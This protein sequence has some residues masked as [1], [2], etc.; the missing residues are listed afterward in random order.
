MRR[1]MTVRG[2]LL[3]GLSATALAAAFAPSAAAR[4]FRRSPQILRVE[5]PL[6]HQ[7][8]NIVIPFVVADVTGRRVDVE[9]QYA[10]DYNADGQITD[11][12]Y[13]PATED[14]L[15]PRNSRADTVPQLYSTGTE[16]GATHAY[17]WKSFSD[18]GP[19]R[20]LT[21]EYVLSP[22]G[23][24]V[25][26]P[27]NP[28]RYLLVTG[29][30]GVTTFLPGVRVRLRTVVARRGHRRRT[31]GDWVVT[32]S[33]SVDNSIP[34]VL[35]ID[36]IESGSPLR[37]HWSVWDAD[38]EDLNGNGV[39]DVADGEDMNGTGQLDDERVGIAFDFHIVWEG[40]D[41]AS[42]TDRQLAA[43]SW[44]PCT[45]V[46]GVGDTDSLDSRPGVQIPS[47]GP[48]AGVASSA[49]PPGRHWVFAWDPVADIGTTWRGFILRATP[50]DER[51]TRGD[52]V[53]SR[54]IVYEAQ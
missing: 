31:Y 21:L 38:S 2:R 36:S 9:V 4:G 53:Y 16:E 14:R 11:D 12:E 33:F 40:E 23:R 25:L 22:Q 20:L 5:Q 26:D 28:G 7:S 41:P 34:P 27:D 15:D 49:Y 24:P 54:T 8:G 47:T 42:M 37:V 19:A 45:R 35:T 29:P 44:I 48:L 39:L 18:L 30:D 10:V 3:V 51:R 32:D 1:R 13:R 6:G 52:T 17:V 50:F 46:E 43:L